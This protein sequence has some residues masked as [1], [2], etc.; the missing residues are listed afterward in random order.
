MVST[1]LASAQTLLH[2]RY[3]ILRILEDGPWS[4]AWLAEDTQ[5]LSGR[6]CV[7]RRVKPLTPDVAVQKQL[8]DRIQT[9][10][11]TW[12]TLGGI[13]DQ[14][15]W[16]S[17][18]TDADN[19]IYLIEEWVPGLTLTQVIQNSGPLDE[20]AVQTIL[21][22]L[23]SLVDYLHQNQVVHCALEPSN[24]VLR[25]AD[26]KPVLQYGGILNQIMAHIC[27][28]CNIH[29]LPWIPTSGYLPHEQVVLDQHY[30][31][32]NLYSLGL[33]GIY[34][35]TGHDPYDVF[36]LTA[37]GGEWSQVVPAADS[38]FTAILNKAIAR[39]PGERFVTAR[40]M[41]KA[42]AAPGQF[43]QQSLSAH[44]NLIEQMGTYLSSYWLHL[45]PSE[46]TLNSYP[47]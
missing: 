26:Q 27:V 18:F 35:L 24:I 20:G 29:P 47:G 13:H 19:Q 41:L 11:E 15:P 34:L 44:A 32:S 25:E 10:I 9:E 8:C 30:Y 28:E 42:L 16:L 21:T 40:Q 36:N 1:G 45:N 37:E 38:A 43:L 31:S 5:R 12:Q 7:V 4:I 3:Q 14:I 46:P 23:L 17:S 33:I 6:Q 22:K 2:N 39:L